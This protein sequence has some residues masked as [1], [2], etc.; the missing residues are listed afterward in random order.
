MGITSPNYK[1]VE[2]SE[3]N[4]KERQGKAKF[5]RMLFAVDAE[6]QIHL[7]WPDVPAGPRHKDFEGV[8]L[9]VWNMGNSQT[10]QHKSPTT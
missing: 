5:I 3:D 1:V 4:M 8:E 6:S 10:N 2:W 9:L 7:R